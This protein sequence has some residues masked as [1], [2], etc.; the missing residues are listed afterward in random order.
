MSEEFKD[1]IGGLE[2]RIHLHKTKLQELQKKRDRVEGE[3]R[4][5]QKYLEMAETLCHVEIEKA[6]QSQAPMPGDEDREGKDADISGQRILLEQTKYVGLS[7][8]NATFSFLKERGG[9]VHAKEIYQKLAQGGVQ[10]R[11]KTPVTSIATSLLRDGRFLK[12]APNTFA[13]V[14]EAGQRSPVGHLTYITERG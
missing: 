7:V 5:T 6:R 10:I 4:T 2:Q 1:I 14:Q 3:I 11:G 8:P 13:L 9:P 12:V